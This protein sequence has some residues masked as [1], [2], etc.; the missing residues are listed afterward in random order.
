MYRQPQNSECDKFIDITNPISQGNWVCFF[1]K[2]K[3]DFSSFAAP[4]SK[5]KKK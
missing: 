2:L 4:I 1:G 5:W 3:I